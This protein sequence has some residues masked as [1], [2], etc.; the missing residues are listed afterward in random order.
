M[1]KTRIL[2][3]YVPFDDEFETRV[4]AAFRS[5]AKRVGIRGIDYRALHI[6]LMELALNA[7]EHSKSPEGGVLLVFE[8]QG[9]EITVRVVDRGIGWRR[10][11]LAASPYRGHGL[12]MVRAMVDHIAI[13][14]YHPG[15]G[16]TISKNVRRA[17]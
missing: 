17:W 10:G 12:Q 11:K 5:F 1:N 16:V 2:K 15:L 7:Y 13:E 3:L 6:A 9:D 4:S 8:A 14:D